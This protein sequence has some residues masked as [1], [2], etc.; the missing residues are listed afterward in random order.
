MQLERTAV[1]DPDPQL[2]VDVM[3]GVAWRMSGQPL[4]DGARPAVAV[5]ASEE[6]RVA[7]RCRPYATFAQPPRNLERNGGQRAAASPWASSTIAW[8]ASDP[9]WPGTAAG[10]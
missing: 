9:T 10:T 2:D 1:V 4:N 5:R 6:D 3:M 7:I 8:A